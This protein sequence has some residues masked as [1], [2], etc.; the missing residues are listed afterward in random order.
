MFVG[1][2]EDTMTN[3]ALLNEYSRS[4]SLDACCVSLGTTP[5]KGDELYKYLAS[6][7]GGEPDK[8]QMA[9]FYKLAGND[10]IGVDYA[11]GDGVS[12]WN[13]RDKQ[14]ESL[15]QQ[16]LLG[17]YEIEKG[18]TRVLYRMKRRGVKID[19]NKL[20]EVHEYASNKVKEAEKKLPVGLNV[21]GPAQIWKN[22]AI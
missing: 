19:V 16:D 2:M 1:T 22:M 12:T 13:L 9:N 20:D 5:K 8:K 14:I 7:F 10:L 21:R 18:M 17:I 15:E 11:V 3:A 6:K 4:F